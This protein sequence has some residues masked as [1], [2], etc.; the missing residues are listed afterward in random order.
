[1]KANPDPAKVHWVARLQNLLTN[2]RT[3]QPAYDF[4]Q[5]FLELSGNPRFDEASFDKI[6]ETC[7]A[8]SNIHKGHKGYVIVGVS[9]KTETAVRVS[10][11]FGVNPTLFGGF[12]VTGVEHEARYLNKN[13]DQLFQVITDKI[14]AS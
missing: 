10:K 12:Q 9:D 5:G 14:R 3:E 7:A 11:L 1:L 4:K 6:L 8:I 2:S 13:L